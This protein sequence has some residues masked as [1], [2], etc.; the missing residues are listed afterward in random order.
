M[1]PLPFLHIR[2]Q[3]DL[4]AKNDGDRG[5]SFLEAMEKLHDLLSKW[6]KEE[7][8]ARTWAQKGELGGDYG[9]LSCPRASG[10]YVNTCYFHDS[11][12]LAVS[13]HW[14]IL[15]KSLEQGYHS[16][17][18]SPLLQKTHEADLPFGWVGERYSDFRP[19]PSRI[20]QNLR[21]YL[22]TI[23][24]PPIHF[25]PRLDGG[26]LLIALLEYS[27]LV[28]VLGTCTVCENKR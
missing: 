9:K 25:S 22:A 17:F 12:C 20:S 18:S 24:T 11:E 28:Y 19:L 26:R 13:S 5:S 14:S 2:M 1:T 21:E 6:Q 16:S 15:H 10:Q 4:L 23:V 7:D 8:K 27:S 3:C